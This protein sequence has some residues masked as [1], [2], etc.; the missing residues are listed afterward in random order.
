MPNS[1][2]YI[3]D[4]VFA[5]SEN[6]ECINSNTKGKIVMPKELQFYGEELF[7]YNK[8]INEFEF[9]TQIDYIQNGT[10]CDTDGFIKVEISKQY[11]YIG[12]YAFSGS[13]EII[14]LK[15][16][17][18]VKIVDDNAFSSCRGIKNLEIGSTV[19][20]IGS[21]A[22]ANCNLIENFKYEGKLKYIGSNMFK[23]KIADFIKDSQLP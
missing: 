9:P 8:K 16:C 23:Y 7:K 22:F 19:T 1:V 13:D 2:K 15:I 20:T 3:G 10:F 21:N 11:K 14:D 5:S 12:A 4:R 18:G 17:E 6:L